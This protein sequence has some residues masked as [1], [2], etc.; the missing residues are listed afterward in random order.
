VFGPSKKERC[1]EKYT[2]LS[3]DF[4]TPDLIDRRIKECMAA[5]VEK[6][7]RGGR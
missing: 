7:A 6:T 3:N 2:D 4:A 1:W 5:F